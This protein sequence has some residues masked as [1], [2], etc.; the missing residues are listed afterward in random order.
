MIFFVMF[1][2]VTWFVNDHEIDTE[3]FEVQQSG[4]D[5]KLL[6]PDVV[7]EDEGVY[8]VVATN[9]HGS[10][11]TSAKLTVTPGKLML[12]KHLLV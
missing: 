6:L 12:V 3:F 9:E 8:S 11:T 4:D 10:V 7:L 2:Q 5:Y 1:W